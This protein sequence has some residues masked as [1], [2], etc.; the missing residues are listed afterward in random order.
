MEYYQGIFNS[1]D[2]QHITDCL[3]VVPNQVSNEMNVELTKPVSNVEI[4]IVVF[5]LGALK[6]PSR[7][8]LNGT[9]FQNYRD[10]VG[11]NICETIKAFFQG[12]L[13][14]RTLMKHKLFLVLET[15]GPEKVGH[16]RPISLY[17]FAYKIIT[18]I[19]C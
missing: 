4:K 10:V 5:S 19:L 16:F 6:S 18:K 14:R 3:S 1:K 17:N 7:D 9:F 11:E 2:M 8:G 15:A 12:G 13:C